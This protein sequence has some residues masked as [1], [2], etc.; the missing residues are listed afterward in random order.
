MF[1]MRKLYGIVERSERRISMTEPLGTIQNIK[2]APSR[3]LCV[4][5]CVYDSERH[6]SQPADMFFSVSLCS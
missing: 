2:E 4:Y 6:K 1:L 3:R 5:E